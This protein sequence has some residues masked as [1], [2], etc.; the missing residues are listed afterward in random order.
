[1]AAETRTALPALVASSDGIRV[2]PA[3]PLG[4][5]QRRPVRL[6]PGERLVLCCIGPRRKPPLGY[7][8]LLS[9]RVEDVLSGSALNVLD[10]VLEGADDGAAAVLTRM[11]PV[12]G[13]AR[14]SHDTREQ[15]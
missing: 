11:G 15:G 1:M 5:A 10:V 8:R 9:G 4:L 14:E 7:L 12:H 13:S 2:L 6:E 3:E